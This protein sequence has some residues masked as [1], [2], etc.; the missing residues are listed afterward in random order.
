MSS[1]GAARIIGPSSAVTRC[2]PMKKD[3]RPYMRAK[4]SSASIRSCQSMRS[5]VKSMSWTAQCWRS[6]S[7]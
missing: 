5:C 2:S 6:H 1:L 3:D 7:E 4:R